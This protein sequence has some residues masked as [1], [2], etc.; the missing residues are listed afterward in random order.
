VRAEVK[1]L[2]VPDLSLPNG[3]AAERLDNRREFL[4]L[5]DRAFRERAERAEFADMDAHTAQAYRMILSPE[6]RRTLMDET[7]SARAS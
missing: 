4:K 6:V 2:K 5:V 3:V 7:D 1:D